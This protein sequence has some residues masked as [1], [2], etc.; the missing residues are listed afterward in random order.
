MKNT[1]KFIAGGL[2]I[3]CLACNT[4][5]EIA[6]ETNYETVELPDGSQV[7]LNQHSAISYEANFTPRTI[8]LDGEAFFRVLP[9]ESP[10]TVTTAHGAIEVLGTEFNVKTTAKEVVVDV[11]KGLV[12][13]KTAYHN[14]KVKKGI[15]AIY[16]DG[17]QAVQQLKSDEEYKKWLL[18]LQK[19]FKKL[20]KELK[21]AL[22]EV[23]HEFKKA[24]KKIGK[25]FKK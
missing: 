20:G 16:N 12:E 3:M 19:E 10:F 7:Y 8:A 24:G 4:K 9:G 21:P 13:I 6:T 14:S 2:L 15:K 18:S 25:E 11:N 5:R 23:G 22:K 1:T 17:E